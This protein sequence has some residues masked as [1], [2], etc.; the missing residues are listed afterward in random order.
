MTDTIYILQVYDNNE[1]VAKSYTRSIE[2]AQSWRY[3]APTW[4]YFTPL[5]EYVPD[6]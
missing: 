1:W 2:E 4:R 6:A 5:N 3:V